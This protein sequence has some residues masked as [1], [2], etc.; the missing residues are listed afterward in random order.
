MSRTFE[1]YEALKLRAET[2]RKF[3]LINVFKKYPEWARE[4]F[5]YVPKDLKSE[6]CYVPKVF[7]NRFM[8]ALERK[9]EYLGYI[10]EAERE[11]KKAG[12]ELRRYQQYFSRYKELAEYRKEYSAIL[13]RVKL[14]RN[15]LKLLWNVVKAQDRLLREIVEEKLKYLHFITLLKEEEITIPLPEPVDLKTELYGNGRYSSDPLAEY[16]TVNGVRIHYLEFLRNGFRI[17]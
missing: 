7:L 6:L 16:T 14:I 15:T 11:L 8:R 5:R 4:H 3:Y 17:L 2:I 1:R 10:R 13:Y 9:R 12:K